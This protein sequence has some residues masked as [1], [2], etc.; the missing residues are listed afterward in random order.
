[1]YLTYF[2]LS[3][4]VGVD[5]FVLRD[6]SKLHN[7][8]VKLE[9]LVLWWQIND[10]WHMTILREML[11]DK[12]VVLLK[13]FVPVFGLFQFFPFLQGDSGKHVQVACHAVV[14]GRR[15]GVIFVKPFPGSERKYVLDLRRHFP[16]RK[17]LN[18]S[19]TIVGELLLAV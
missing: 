13:V 8:V 2:N 19:Y 14:E 3:F 16:A 1:M 5:H 9:F 10:R 11:V 15:A 7:G 4:V 12:S 17:G 18:L 6:R